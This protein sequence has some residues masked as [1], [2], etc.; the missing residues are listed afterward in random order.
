MKY[1]HLRGR[2]NHCPLDQ[3]VARTPKDRRLLRQPPLHPHEQPGPRDHPA[4]AGSHGWGA[5]GLDIVRIP[6]KADTVYV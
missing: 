3:Q 2:R 5:G 1:P 6:V 4:E